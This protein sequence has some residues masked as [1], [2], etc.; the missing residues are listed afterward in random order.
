MEHSEKGYEYPYVSI[1][2]FVQVH[3]LDRP[4]RPMVLVFPLQRPLIPFPLGFFTPCL[5]WIAL[6]RAEFSRVEVPTHR[7]ALSAGT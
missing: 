5:Q 1:N 6:C 7:R 4:D 3:V 2:A